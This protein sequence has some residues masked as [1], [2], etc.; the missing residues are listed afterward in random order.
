MSA[1]PSESNSVLDYGKKDTPQPSY[2]QHR[3]TEFKKTLWKIVF[4]VLLV[5]CTV[6]FLVPFL[7]LL[8]A[9]LKVLLHGKTTSTS[10]KSHP[11]WIGS[12]TA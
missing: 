9:S 7:W 4:I 2:Q 3:N 5:T 11:F 12:K 6:I 1:I 10:G 8:S